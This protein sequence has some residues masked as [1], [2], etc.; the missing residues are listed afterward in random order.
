MTFDANNGPLAGPGLG[1]AH[2]ASFTFDGNPDTRN[3]KE[4]S[5]APVEEQ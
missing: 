3:R 5:V 4:S 1:H 2:T